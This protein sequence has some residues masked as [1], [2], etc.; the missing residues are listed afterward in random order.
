MKRHPLIKG[1]ATPKCETVKTRWQGAVLTRRTPGNAPTI[2]G[3]VYMDYFPRYSARPR[4][5]K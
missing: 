1:K 2:D 4:V 5:M 3:R